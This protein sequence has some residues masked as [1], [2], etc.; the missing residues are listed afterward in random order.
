M[1]K[2]NILVIGG[3]PAGVIAAVTAKKKN[4]TKKVILIREN[5]ISVI[6][7][8]IP[9][10]FNRLD[11]VKKDIL[12]DKSLLDNK[13]GIIIDKA[14][15]IS[16]LE[17]IVI[18]ASKKHIQYDRL[19]I[20]TGSKPIKIPIDGI[21]K[22]GVWQVKKDFEY[23]KKLRRAVVK[24]KKIVII[25]GGYIG[26][27]LAEELSNIKSKKITIFEKMDHCLGTTM[28]REFT[29][30][31][32]KRLIKKGVDIHTQAEVKEIGGKDKVRYVILKNQKKILADLVIVS[33][34]AKPNI[35]IIQGTKIKQGQYRG[36]E[37]DQYMRTNIT[38]I[39]AVGDCAE[40]RE[41]FTKKTIPIMLATTACYEARVAGMN[42]YER[43]R[44]IKNHGTLAC[45]STSINGMAFGAVGL[46]KKN[47]H[48]K[49]VV[50]TSQ[51]PSHH[52]G[53]LPDTSLIT[54]ELIF[55]KSG[56]ILLGGQIMGPES[57]GEMLNIIALAI[58]K[59]TTIYDM[60]T[61]QIA[62]HPL[63]TPSPTIYPLVTAAQS[64]LSK[65]K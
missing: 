12:P 51:C 28:D 42:I 37:V 50:G 17:K 22:K 40:T 46:N 5:K 47:I 32:E 64:V 2:T 18:L 55:S 52:P 24:A 45:F 61:L 23:L 53:F 44:L 56:G 9:Y 31:A 49:I 10:V 54:V 26:V 7:C 59:Q 19:I 6:P 36:I 62:S 65:V 57:S 29:E 30:V 13:I 58:Q 27:E 21:G 20:A 48:K 41:F 33:V 16:T 3:G 34:G 60:S 43:N 4:P 15:S 25:G 1:T 11:S 14:L 63:L 39:F 8:G 35:D 38:D